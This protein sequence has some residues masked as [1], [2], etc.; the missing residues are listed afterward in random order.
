MET[1]IK[2]VGRMASWVIKVSQVARNYASIPTTI[3]HY[4]SPNGL[5]GIITN[6]ELWFSR[7][8]CLNDAGEG[9]YVTDVYK[10]AI[11]SLRGKINDK[12]L[13]NIYDVEP[14]FRQFFKIKDG[15]VEPRN[16]LRL[17]RS[18]TATPY[19]CCFSQYNDS[20]PM[21]NYYSKGGQ[22]EGYNVG[23]NY[24]PIVDSNENVN[25]YR[26]IYKEEDQ[27][28]ILAT[29]I[30]E[31]YVNYSEHDNSIELIR[32]RLK[33]ELSTRGIQFKHPAFEHENEVRLVYWRPNDDDN[34]ENKKEKIYYRQIHGIVIP[35]IKLGVKLEEVVQSVT[36]GPLIKR[37]V[38]EK[39]V[40]CL[41]NENGISIPIEKSELPVRY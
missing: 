8:D 39:T 12:F 26:A 13:D 34:L 37:D 24:L 33:K 7:F 15:L 28:S 38:A 17:E 23:F 22:Y 40:K 6:K 41:L 10:K 25:V 11:H 27:I 9:Q 5:I 31:G 14:D 30:E 3:Y 16:N 36:I 18:V 35:Y 32:H 2:E 21:W 1:A 19:L 29:R 20:L 4:T